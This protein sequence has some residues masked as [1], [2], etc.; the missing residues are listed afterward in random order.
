M[1]QILVTAMAFDAVRGG[2]S[3]R[4]AY[5]LA[6]GLVHR[7]HQVTVVCND[8]F[9]SGIEHE[10]ENGITILRYRLPRSD[11]LEPRRHEEHIR[12][13]KK[14]VIKYLNQPPAVVHGHHLLQYFA[15][16]DLFKTQV[17]SCYTIHSPAIDELRITWGAQGLAGKLKSL[18]GLSVIRK[19]ETSILNHSTVLA[20][21]SQFIK[22]LIAHHYGDIL[23]Q[24]LQVIPG[25]ADASRFQILRNEQIRAARQQ[26]GWPGDVPVFFVLRRLEPRMGLDNFLQALAIVKKRGFNPY[27]VIGGSGSLELHLKR[28]CDRLGLQDKVNFLG[29]VPAVQVPLAYGACDASVIPTSQLE[30]FGL[31]ALEALACGKTTLVTPV[32]ALP[33]VMGDFEPEWIA[34]DST[35]EGIADL[36]VAFMQNRLPTHP[37]Q[38]LRDR[39]MRKYSF[40]QSLNAYE[41]ILSNKD[42]PKD[43]LSFF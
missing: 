2:G 7:G 32:G 39:V 3:T 29:F 38:D 24:K 6:A 30:G 5:D 36:L 37:P 27:S 9:D 40:E 41:N 31:I 20:A 4:L 25:W 26:L 10:V 1:S 33:E 18:F 28:L 17:R 34:R 21:E 13:V 11:R 14:L 23:A 15:V 19:L 42:F 43:E 16:L 12:A 8:M 35:P 22:Y